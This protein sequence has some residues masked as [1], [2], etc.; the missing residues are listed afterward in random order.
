[1]RHRNR[2]GRYPL[3]GIVFGSG[4][5]F[6]SLGIWAVTA[7]PAHAAFAGTNG[8][9][10][11]AS[12]RSNGATFGGL[13]TVDAEAPNLGS[14][15]GDQTATSG[16]TDGGNG[17][18]IDSEPFYSPDGSTVFFAS[19]RS[20]N[21]VWVIYS[22]PS[23]SPEPPGAPTELSQPPGSESADDYAPSVAMD[24][25]TVVFNRNDTSLDTL[26]A[27]AS[28]PWT[29]VCTLYTPA[30]G[31]AAT[32]TEGATS[33]AVFDP[34]DPTQLVYVGGDNHLH[35]V[36]G[37]PRPAA[38]AP[39]NPCGAVA[40]QN[41][42]TDTDLSA[43]AI[44]STT[45]TTDATGTYQDESPDWSPNGTAIVFDSTRGGTNHTLWTLT[46]L[47]SGTLTAAPLWP[48]QVGTGGGRKSETQPVFSPDGTQIAFV[49]PGP[50]TNVWNGEIVG[51]GAALSSEQ[52]VSLS[53]DGT[54]TENDQPDW[55][56]SGPGQG[57][58]EVPFALLLPGS[59]LMLAGGFLLV[60][61]R[62]RGAP[63]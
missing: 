58:P 5:T 56:P 61:R 27:E 22:I 10:V 15:S 47:T 25:R 6:L 1:L 11:F 13:F 14:N 16:L 34:V 36:K 37:L 43:T 48:S 49:Q 35:L 59:A 62:R 9:I 54:G 30:V 28:S 2:T 63:A 8:N 32:S 21:G 60:Q 20:A 4:L 39:T 7:A 57:T 23:G 26:D 24:G 3:A 41:G 50:G 52:N 42:V 38:T 33:R 19:N 55:G 45:G 17:S 44:D 40:G 53:T 12:T 31:L 51:M 46:N 29:H 18:G